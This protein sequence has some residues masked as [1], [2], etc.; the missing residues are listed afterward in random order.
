MKEYVEIRMIIQD[1]VERIQF[2]V[3]DLG[4]LDVHIHWI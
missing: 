2:A 1:H 3:S 4:D